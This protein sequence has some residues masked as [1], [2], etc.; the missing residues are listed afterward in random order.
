MENVLFKLINKKN[1]KIDINSKL[2][3][4][5]LLFKFLS[6]HGFNVD[7]S[8]FNEYHA[9]SR[10]FDIEYG[11]NCNFKDIYILA[12]ILKDYGLRWVSVSEFNDSDV[13]LGTGVRETERGHNVNY[14]TL[15]TIEDFLN[16]DPNIENAEAMSLHFVILGNDEYFPTGDEWM[17]YAQSEINT[18]DI[19]TDGSWRWNV[20]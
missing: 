13:R 6:F 1:L 16:I 17:S 2:P 8:F 5:E 3:T 12:Y 14:T 10:F 19:E 11:Q 9:D 15:L 4:Y 20:D 18:M 7:S